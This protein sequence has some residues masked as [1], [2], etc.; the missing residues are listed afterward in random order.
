ML[1]E[2]LKKVNITPRG[3]EIDLQYEI[4]LS[5]SIPEDSL[6]N[7][8]E[9]LKLASSFATNFK[10]QSDESERVIK[11][12]SPAYIIRT[13]AKIKFDKDVS[14]TLQHTAKDSKDMVVLKADIPE[15]GRPHQTSSVPEF[16]ELKDPDV[17][18][19]TGEQ[20]VV[21]KLTSLSS[22]SY[23]IGKKKTESD[24]ST[25]TKHSKQATYI[26]RMGGCIYLTQGGRK[27]IMR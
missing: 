26:A 5:I 6:R 13:T 3:K 25:G 16:A 17:D 12:V 11:P 24:D 19:K 4:G 15:E 2:P 7:S 9:N 23:M 20:C 14:I 8:D 21:L 1:L 10:I 18:I 27:M 22:S